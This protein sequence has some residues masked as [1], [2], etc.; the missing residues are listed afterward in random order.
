MRGADIS[1]KEHD[2][3]MGAITGYNLM[4]AP[5]FYISQVDIVGPFSAYSP[6]NKRSTIKIW[7]V[8]FCCATT[9]ATSIKVMEDYSTSAFLHAFTRFACDAGYPKT[10]LVDEG[11]QLVKG[12][13]TMTIQFWDLKFQLHRDVGMDFEVIPVGG[14]NFNGKVERKIREIR[15]SMNKTMN[16]LRLSLMQWET[17]AATVANSLN[18]MPLALG[19]FSKS[20]LEFMDL[21]TPNRLKLGRNNER[22]PVG[23]V[24][25][26]DKEKIIREN[27]AIFEAWFEVWLLC[28]VPKLMHQPKWFRSGKDLKEGDV[29]LFLKQE[30]AIGSNYQF[31]IVESVDAG[32]DQKVRKVTVRYRNHSE[33][34]DRY[35]TRAARSLVVIRH[36]DEMSIMEELGEVSRYVENKR[37]LNAGGKDPSTAGECNIVTNSTASSL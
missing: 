32:R 24:V 14:H 28:H 35:T 13:E 6:H 36:A 18:N 21:I 10:L 12:C 16:N 4:I 17:L 2:V 27:Q 33:S 1:T 30:S 26:A 23:E 15:K 22:S 5:G 34:T 25:F 31:G 9:S 19:N 11:S 8:V 3:T 37:K 29:V 7:M 20:N